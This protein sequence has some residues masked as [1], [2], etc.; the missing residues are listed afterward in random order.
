MCMP[1]I[2][3]GILFLSQIIRNYN[4]T[5]DIDITNTFYKMVDIYMLGLS[6]ENGF[7]SGLLS[8][9]GYFL[10][11]AGLDVEGLNITPILFLAGQIGYMVLVELLH[12]LYDL[13]IFIPRA[14]RSLVERGM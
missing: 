2:L 6:S 14:C 4:S 9:L 8:G 5:Y 1:L 13:I 3:L 10:T 11:I 7:M 12:L